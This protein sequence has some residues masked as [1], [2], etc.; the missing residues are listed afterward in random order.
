MHED[1]LYTPQ[2]L[3]L[4]PPTTNRRSLSMDAVIADMKNAK[5]ALPTSVRTGADENRFE[6]ARHTTAKQSEPPTP[7]T[8]D[9]E[10]RVPF[11]RSIVASDTSCGIQNETRSVISQSCDHEFFRR[12]MKCR[13]TYQREA[14]RQAKKLASGRRRFE[15]LQRDSHVVDIATMDDLRKEHQQMINADA[16]MRTVAHLGG[17]NGVINRS[18]GVG[19]E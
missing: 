7:P 1:Y 11:R 9:E 16:Q 2:A 3:F 5:L 18:S 4:Y 10:S 15:A 12:A 8:M 13:R 14:K 17:G 19:A 6:T